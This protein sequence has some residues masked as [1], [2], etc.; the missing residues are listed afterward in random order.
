MVVLPAVQLQQERS[1]LWWVDQADRA[2]GRRNRVQARFHK[3]AGRRQMH[4]DPVLSLLSQQKE[5]KG[6]KEAFPDA[7]CIMAVTMEDLY[8]DPTDLF[9]AGMA[10]GGSHVAV[11]SFARYQPGFH[12]SREHWFEWSPVAYQHCHPLGRGDLAVGGAVAAEGP[13][14]HAAGPREVLARGTKRKGRTAPKTKRKRTEVSK[15]KA[16]KG[17]AGGKMEEAQA[18]PLPGGSL[19]QRSIKLLVHEL[20]HL[21]HLDHCVHHACCMNGSGHL[22]EDFRQPMFLCPVCLRK[23]R[24]RLGPSFDLPARYQKMLT[25]FKEHYMPECADWVQ[26]RLH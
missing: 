16:G 8:S 6:F 21:Y 22:D 11:F 24:C 23:L 13:L 14:C 10:A 26:R 2:T 18:C 15:G 12:F 20:G 3:A 5:S 25:F 17:K 7:F 9:V 1:T 4:V 19:L